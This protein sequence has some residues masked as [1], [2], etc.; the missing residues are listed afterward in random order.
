MVELLAR[1]RRS[2]NILSI[3]LFFFL[4]LTAKYACLPAS[5]VYSNCMNGGAVRSYF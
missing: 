5:I 1:D 4:F 2:L 3:I